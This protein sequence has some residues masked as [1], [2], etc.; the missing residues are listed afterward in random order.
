MIKESNHV[1]NF[2][3]KTKLSPQLEVKHENKNFVFGWVTVY[4][5]TLLILK[6]V[7]ILEKINGI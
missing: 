1:H 2:S 7:G 5:E 4:F 3:C 6:F